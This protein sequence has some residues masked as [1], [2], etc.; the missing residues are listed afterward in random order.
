MYFNIH[1]AK[2]SIRQVGENIR[3]V[4]FNHKLVPFIVGESPLLTEGVSGTGRCAT[5]SL[6][7]LTL[8]PHFFVETAE[9]LKQICEKATVN[10][11]F[12]NKNIFIVKLSTDKI[13]RKIEDP[14]AEFIKQEYYDHPEKFKCIFQEEYLPYL[15]LFV[16]GIYWDQRYPRLIKQSFLSD[17]YKYHPLT[18]DARG[19]CACWRF[20]T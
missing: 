2:N 16:N 14:S 5:G 18:P 8:L 19:P 17:Y 1:H 13:M 20:R 11:D 10:P 3:H 15:S 12:Y 6:E 4:G 9:E 7:I